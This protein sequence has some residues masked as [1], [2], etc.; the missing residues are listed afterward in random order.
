MRDQI[1]ISYSHADNAH[2][3]RLRKHLAVFE[4]SGNMKYWSDT[5]LRTGEQWRQQI[6]DNIEKTA[7]AILLISADFLASDFI[8]SNELP[9][10]LDAWTQNGVYILPVIV[11]PC[12]FSHVRELSRFQA[13]NDPERTIEEMSIAEQ[14]R[15]WKNLAETAYERLLEYQNTHREPVP[16]VVDLTRIPINVNI[17]IEEEDSTPPASPILTPDEQGYYMAQIAQVRHPINPK[18]RCFQLRGLLDQVSQ[19]VPGETHWLFYPTGEFNDPQVND[20]VKFRVKSIRPLRDFP[21]IKN[22]RNIY[23]YC[24]DILSY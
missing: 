22:T 21:D 23:L 3:L 6:Q 19:Y 16:E 8:R 9:P 14:E 24:L 20:W 2:Q 1:F 17:E 15:T 12:S 18:F 13:V 11:K 7:V 10:L 5:Q 4:R